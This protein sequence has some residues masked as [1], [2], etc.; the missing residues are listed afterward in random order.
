MWWLLFL[1]LVGVIILVVTRFPPLAVRPRPPAAR[2]DDFDAHPRHVCRGD[3]VTASWRGDGESGSL[4]ATIPAP[5]GPFFS[6]TVDPSLLP[7]GSSSFPANTDGDFEVELVLSRREAASDSR[8]VTIRG[9]DS[10]NAIF[11]LTVQPT[12]MGSPREGWVGRR[13]FSSDPAMDIDDWSPRIAVAGLRYRDASGRDIMVSW[14]G[15]PL[16]T[17][18][19]RE[20]DHFNSLDV[21]V[22]GE[23][24][25][26]VPAGPG[27]GPHTPL[28]VISI[29]LRLRCVAR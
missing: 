22:A 14:N 9:H 21:R 23:W 12:F 5:V 7:V 16:A 15:T 6:Q 11:R 19:T 18:S 10:P 1:G 26:F 27:D 4:T 25:L 29:D 3:V 24:V 13:S 20:P 8:R 17:L 28:P 2:I